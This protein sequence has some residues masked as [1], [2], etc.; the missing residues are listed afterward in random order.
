MIPTKH[1]S[2]P[3]QRQRSRREPSKRELRIISTLAVIAFVIAW[4]L[5]A[6]H[7]WIE[8]LF[9]SSPTRI[10]SAFRELVRSGELQRNSVASLKLFASGLLL[11]LAVG[12]PLG[13]VV[14]WYRRINAAIDPFISILY[15]TPRLALI[16]LILLW[17]GVGDQ[18]RTVVVFLTAFFPILIS[19]TSGV[20]EIDPQLMHVARVF[21]ANDLQIFRT[22][23]IPTA[24]PYI[25]TGTRL[26]IGQALIGVVVA[27]FFLGQVGIGSMIT[28]AGYTLRSDVAMVGI[29]VVAASSLVLT[30][31]LRCLE[32][33]FA[34]WRPAIEHG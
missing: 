3:A 29:L 2:P 6:R 5:S 19:T 28:R 11:A 10:F 21:G 13:I 25:M 17:F 9:T 20:R 18:S 30:A 24:L 7:G 4:E 34:R 31:L 26:A 15:A 1:D 32:R 14:G 33:R 12:V 27:E 23:A 8:P 22:L 16:P